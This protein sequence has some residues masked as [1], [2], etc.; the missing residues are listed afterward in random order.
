MPTPTCR[1]SARSRACSLAQLLVPDHLGRPLERRQVVAAVV[2]E[3]RRV[4]EHD[5]RGCAGSGRARAGCACGSR[6][7]RCPSSFAAMSSSRSLTNTPCWRP[8]PRTGVT[9]G[10]F[11]NTA[12]NSA[13]VVGDVVRAEQ[14]ALRVDR[15]RQAVRIVGAGVEQETSLHAEDAAVPR[16]RHLG[17]VHLPALLRRRVEVL[18]AILGP[19][20]RPSEAHRRPRARAVP[21]GRTS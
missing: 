18:A 5:A 7:G 17:V 15:N 4:L 20:H 12:V 16:E 19:L 2:D 1:P 3:R 11:V 8:A 14:R 10:L 6:R 21:P 13:V 9:I